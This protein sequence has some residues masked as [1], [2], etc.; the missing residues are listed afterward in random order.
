METLGPYHKLGRIFI[1][2]LDHCMGSD[3]D[4]MLR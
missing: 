4:I 1:D 3:Q 2:H